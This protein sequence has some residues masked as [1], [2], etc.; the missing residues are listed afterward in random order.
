MDCR[1]GYE[2][3]PKLKWLLCTEKPHHFHG[4]LITPREW[5]R[6][7]FSKE[8]VSFLLEEAKTLPEIGRLIAQ[9]PNSLLDKAAVMALSFN[10]FAYDF[11]K[12]FLPQYREN[13][14]M[15]KAYLKN[16]VVNTAE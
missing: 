7:S 16:I 15:L 14:S 13:M 3:S 2:N 11:D 6:R 4:G 10:Y 1:A 12:P 8:E 5:Q 9:I